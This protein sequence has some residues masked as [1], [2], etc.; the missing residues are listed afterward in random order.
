MT[1]TATEKRS[2]DERG[3]GKERRRRERLRNSTDSLG[4]D[5]QWNRNAL[6]VSETEKQK[7]HA[8]GIRQRGWKYENRH[9]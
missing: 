8:G 2:T 6:T 4:R 3:N 9:K 5:L 1:I 7:Y